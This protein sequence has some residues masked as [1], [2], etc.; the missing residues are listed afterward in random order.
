VANAE[1]VQG[2]RVKPE[3][4]ATVAAAVSAAAA[5]STMLVF[6]IQA[7]HMGRKNVFDALMRANEM[8]ATRF[9][10]RDKASEF[11]ELR[12]AFKDDSAVPPAVAVDP[13]PHL[14]FSPVANPEWGNEAYHRSLRER[15]VIVNKL[16]NAEREQCL[17]LI[18]PYVGRMNDLGELIH[19]GFVDPKAI[20][21]KIHLSIA[22]EV[23]I[24]EPFIYRE[25]IWG[26]R[27]RWGFRVLRLGEMARAYNDLNSIH[28]EP[29]FFFNRRIRDD[30][31]GPIY[32][33]PPRNRRFK[34]RAFIRLHML[35]YPTINKRVQ[36]QQQQYLERLREE[37]RAH[38]TAAPPPPP[39][40]VSAT[41]DAGS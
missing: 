12:R 32:Q 38:G 9:E 28:R 5:L 21:S 18:E 30:D 14:A 11:R 26:Q 15:I 25:M 10:S 20:L 29:I 36:R 33:H 34:V 6:W 16:S 23:F 3:V 24:A 7:R 4:V 41:S 40:A 31:Y 37:L 17:D 35:G 8:F 27:G 39:E 13:P 1:P 22:R 19:L 2:E